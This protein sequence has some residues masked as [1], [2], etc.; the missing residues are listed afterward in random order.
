M[1]IRRSPDRFQTSNTNASPVR[2]KPTKMS[3]TAPK[4]FLAEN[5]PSLLRFMAANLHPTSS[6]AVVHGLPQTPVFK[7]KVSVSA[8]RLQ[9]GPPPGKQRA[10]MGPGAVNVGGGWT[11]RAGSS[12]S[13]ESQLT[14]VIPLGI[15]QKPTNLPEL[16]TSKVAMVARWG[17][18][19]AL[20][21][22]STLAGISVR[23]RRRG[24]QHRQGVRGPPADSSV[25][26][27]S[28]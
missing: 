11:A 8:V 20:L 2:F 19:T 5:L 25:S 17:G 6:S 13:S 7:R 21:I 22:L 16:R 3:P 27:D 1:V 18:D 26:A 4:N 12:R 14:R 23:G 24:S 10:T 15:P 9:V 28:D